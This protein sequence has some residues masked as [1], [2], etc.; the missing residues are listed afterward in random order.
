MKKLIFGFLAIVMTTGVFFISC[1]K[2]ETIETEKANTQNK[3]ISF[4]RTKINENTEIFVIKEMKTS[5]LDFQKHLDG[6]IY[7]IDM[8]S[9][10]VII[11]KENEVGSIVCNLIKINDT[12][13]R[14]SIINE[15]TNLR[16]ALPR[17]ICVAKCALQGAVI[18]ASDGPAPFMD[19]APIMYT[20]ACAKDC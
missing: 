17:W 19:L 11:T 5:E 1:S 4:K 14:F 10:T 12:N 16:T 3:I 9:K 18:A 20:I 7:T 2:E 15:S 6:L 13:Y 8:T